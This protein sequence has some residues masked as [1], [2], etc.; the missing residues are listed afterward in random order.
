M[1]GAL[2]KK[3]I[4]ILTAATALMSAPALAADLRRPPPPAPV[5]APV[6]FYNWT[7]FYIGVQGGFGW[8]DLERTLV[9]TGVTH[10]TETSGGLFGGTVGFNWQAGAWVFGFEADYAWADIGRS[11]DNC[12]GVAFVTCRSGLDTFGTARL[13]LGGAWGPVLI[14]GTGGLAFGDHFALV[15]NNLTGL[16]AER[17]EFAVGWT[18]GGGVEWGFAPGWSLKAEAL[19]FDLDVD[20]LNTPNLAFLEP[21]GIDIRHTGVIVR[22]GINYRFNWGGPPVRSY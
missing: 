4:H 3:L 19:Y 2:M 22:G 15:E 12:F 21:V 16:F 20:R 6:P 13:R 9:T 17:S 11:V 1:E 8:A 5:A 18:V 14:Y 10:T 7:G